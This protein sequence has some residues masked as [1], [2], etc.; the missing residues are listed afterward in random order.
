MKEGQKQGTV[1][2]LVSSSPGG[3]SGVNHLIHLHRR[4]L[5]LEPSVQLFPFAVSRNYQVGIMAHEVASRS[6]KQN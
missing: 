2:R 5:R 3:L 4:K 1:K 6:F